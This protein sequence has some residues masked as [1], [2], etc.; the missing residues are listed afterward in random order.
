MDHS[1]PEIDQI[2]PSSIRHFRFVKFSILEV[3]K[4]TSKISKLRFSPRIFLKRIQEI[5]KSQSQISNWDV[6]N[7]MSWKRAKTSCYAQEKL[8]LK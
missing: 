3:R 1:H 5:Q 7:K 2:L 8:E 6:A 4:K